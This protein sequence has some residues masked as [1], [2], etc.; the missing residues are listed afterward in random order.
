M[1]KGSQHCKIVLNDKSN[2]ILSELLKPLRRVQRTGTGMSYN[3]LLD[4]TLRLFRA[5]RSARNY[6]CRVLT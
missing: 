2:A 3:V 5:I 4:E 6:S 1:T